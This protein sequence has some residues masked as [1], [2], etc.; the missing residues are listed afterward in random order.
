MHGDGPIA[1]EQG[2]GY[3]PVAV[4]LDQQGQHVRFAVGKVELGPGGG[5]AGG[6]AGLAGQPRAPGQ[7]LGQAQ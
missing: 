3:L 7:I 4:A 5:R 6:R 1:D 2:A